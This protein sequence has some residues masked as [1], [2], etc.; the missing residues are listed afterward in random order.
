L[1]FAPTDTNYFDFVRSGTNPFNGCGFINYL[2]G[3]IGVFG[4]VAP[5]T[6]EVRV[7][8]PQHDPREGVYRIFGGANGVDVRWDV[9]LDAASAPDEFSALTDGT[10]IEGPVFSSVD[11]TFGGGFHAIFH[12]LPA[13]PLATT[14]VVYLLDYNGPLTPRG[15]SF[16]ATLRTAVGD[17][18]TTTDRVSVVQLSGP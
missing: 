7:T 16:T 13:D 14:R 17:K 4:S 15:T 5:Q 6:N 2:S 18:P 1:S 11:G 12:G 3:G 10:W 9:Y 8:A